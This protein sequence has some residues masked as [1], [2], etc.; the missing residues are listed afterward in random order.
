MGGVLKK[1]KYRKAIDKKCN[2]RA[3]FG[4]LKTMLYPLLKLMLPGRALGLENLPEKG[5]YILAFNHRSM[6][7]APAAFS[8]IPMYWHFIAK[9][10][11][12]N[13]AFFRWLLP[14]LG[15]VGVNRSNIDLSTIR[16]VVALLGKGEV[17]GIFPE[18]TRSKTGE[19]AEMKAGAFKMATKAKAKIV[20]VAMKNTRCAFE[21]ADSLRPVNVYVRIMKPIDTA[22][23]DEEGIKNVHAIVEKEIREAFAELPG[24]YGRA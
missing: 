3:W 1:E 13:H 2:Y 24:P 7:D 19:I 11:F 12:Y 10:E 6:L 9:E 20:P 16:R 18:G 8:S 22:E 21:S 14:R 23:L 5:G 4:F 17:L 15:V